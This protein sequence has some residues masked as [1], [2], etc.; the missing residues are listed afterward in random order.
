MWWRCQDCPLVPHSEGRSFCMWKI[1]FTFPPLDLLNLNLVHF[2]SEL[3]RRFHPLKGEKADLNIRVRCVWSWWKQTKTSSAH[4]W[5]NLPAN[6][7][8]GGFRSA[9]WGSAEHKE[10][11]KKRRRREGERDF[12]ISLLMVSGS[13]ELK[14]QHFLYSRKRTL[15][16]FLFCQLLPYVHNINH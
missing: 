14:P 4:L 12:M 5:R 11:K 15:S 9:E 7:E 1:T 10:E 6:D 3:D 8:T 16:D 13:S 2:F